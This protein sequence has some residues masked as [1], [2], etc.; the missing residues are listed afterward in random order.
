MLR[1]YRAWHDQYDDPNSSLAERLRIVQRRLDELLTAAP[2]GPIRLISMCAGQGRDVLGVVPKH[3][4]QS[5]VSAVL[6]ELNP[7]NVRSAR[8]AAAGAGL[9]SLV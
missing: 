4:R 7:A 9:R 1:D 2:S 8:E 3:K 5:D 6:V